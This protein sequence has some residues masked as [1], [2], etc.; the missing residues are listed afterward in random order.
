MWEIIADP[1]E[2]GIE[3]LEDGINNHKEVFS[4]EDRKKWAEEIG[5]FISKLGGMSDKAKDLQNLFA[6]T[7]EIQVTPSSLKTLKIELFN[8]N[9]AVNKA[10]DVAD[11]IEKQIIKK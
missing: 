3:A 7:D 11:R 1:A 6:G 5:N 9:D 2:Y 4:E 8:I 10:L